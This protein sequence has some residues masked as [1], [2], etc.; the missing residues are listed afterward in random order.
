M[1]IYLLF[2]N[3]HA[4]TLLN[5]EVWVTGGRNGPLVTEVYMQ[6]VDIF[7]LNTN[8]WRTAE[9]MK[10]ARAYHTAATVNGTVAVYGGI[11]AENTMELYTP[12]VGWVETTMEH[13]HLAHSSVVVP[14][15]A[16]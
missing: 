7:N 10:K 4:C 5:D 16:P 8:T 13:K 14:C 2:R 6:E 9:G 15:P 12:G 3:A 1:N 11:R